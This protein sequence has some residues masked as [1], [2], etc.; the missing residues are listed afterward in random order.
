[1]V[2]HGQMS[3]KINENDPESPTFEKALRMLPVT[4]TDYVEDDMWQIDKINSVMR[5]LIAG[6]SLP[7]YDVETIMDFTSPGSDE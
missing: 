1:M 5:L 4:G 3:S 6:G 7:K 2:Y